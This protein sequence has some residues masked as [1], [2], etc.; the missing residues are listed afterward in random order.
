MPYSNNKSVLVSSS[1]TSAATSKK[2]THCTRIQVQQ[3]PKAELPQYFSRNF[4]SRSRQIKWQKV[5]STL[6]FPL[7]YIN[8]KCRERRCVTLITERNEALLEELLEFERKLSGMLHPNLWKQTSEETC[9]AS[10]SSWVQTPTGPKTRVF[11]KLV[12]FIMFKILS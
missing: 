3:R 11:K 4:S 5:R 2:Y 9:S 10:G 8:K 6:C 12:R 7:I 1:F